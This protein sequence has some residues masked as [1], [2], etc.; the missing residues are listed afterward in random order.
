[1]SPPFN[2]FLSKHS[3]S[4]KLLLNGTAN[5]WESN[6][7]YRTCIAYTEGEIVEVM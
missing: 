3:V 7:I 6:T 1:M 4:M 5:N 2:N